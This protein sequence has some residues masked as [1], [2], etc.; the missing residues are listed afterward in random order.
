[1]KEYFVNTLG[2]QRRAG[3]T[4]DDRR[5]SD[6]LITLAQRLE[7][8]HPDQT[9]AHLLLSEAYIQ[10]AKD[11]F[12]EEGEPVIGWVQLALQAANQ[13]ATI[14]PANHHV[15]TLITYCH[16]RLNKLATSQ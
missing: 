11:A 13:A 5:I 16:T 8:L 12:R 4:K 9:A 7:Q 1:M 6:R 14:D 10:R 15:Q 2:W 3:I